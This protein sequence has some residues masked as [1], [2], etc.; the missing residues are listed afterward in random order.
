[1]VFTGHHP[2]LPKC[3]QS[4][5]LSLWKQRNFW[6]WRQRDVTEEVSRGN[7]AEKEFRVIQTVGRTWSTIA[8]IKDG[9]K[10]KWEKEC[11]C[12]LEA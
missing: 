6:G 7:E 3:A 12:L 2:G 8:D 10:E 11:E 4:N 1:M 5:E 9:A